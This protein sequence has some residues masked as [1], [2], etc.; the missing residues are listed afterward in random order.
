MHP[1][2]V[3][4]PLLQQLG[5]VGDRGIRR[6]SDKHSPLGHISPVI[7]SVASAQQTESLLFNLMISNTVYPNWRSFLER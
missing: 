2:I 5:V 7:S 6:Y 1:C 4:D 3:R